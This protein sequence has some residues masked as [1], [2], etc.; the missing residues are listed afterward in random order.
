M[1]PDVIYSLTSCGSK[2][3]ACNWMEVKLEVNDKGPLKFIECVIKRGETIR[4]RPMRKCVRPKGL[5]RLGVLRGASEGFGDRFQR[6]RNRLVTAG[7]AELHFAVMRQWRIRKKQNDC[8]DEDAAPTLRVC[9]HPVSEQFPWGKAGPFAMYGNGEG[10]V[11]A[12]DTAT[13][14]LAQVIES[15]GNA[16]RY[17]NPTSFRSSFVDSHVDGDATPKIEFVMPQIPQQARAPEFQ[18]WQSLRCERL[19]SQI[20]Q[21]QLHLPPKR[22]PKAAE[23]LLSD[24]I[25]CR[26]QQVYV[27]VSRLEK[28]PLRQYYTQSEKG[29]PAEVGAIR[30]SLFKVWER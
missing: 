13:N 28:L 16:W 4:R 12:L 5:R 29:D 18:P 23:P 11:S 30:K 25:P 21:A 20:E 2:R 19:A 26:R 14:D 24:S 1:V 10:V 15:G 7:I 3:S 22:L 17:T 8:L 27:N 6:S 9:P